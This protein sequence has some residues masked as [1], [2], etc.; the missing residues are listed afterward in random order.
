MSDNIIKSYSELIIRIKNNILSSRYHAATL[1]NKELLILY[2][3]IGK[4]ISDKTKTEKWGSKVLN[5]I[6]DDLQ[7]ELPGLRGFS[8][9]NMKKMRVF[10]EGWSKL[11]SISSISLNQ[12]ELISK[13]ESQIG[14]M[15]LNQFIE[16]FF[17]IGFSSHYLIVSKAKTLEERLFY[18]INILNN[19]W[20]VD[21]LKYHLKTSLY[22]QK[23]TLPT[24]FGKTI[25]KKD[26]RAKALGTFKDE[27]LLEYINIEDPDE[28]DEKLIENEIVRNIKKF[29]MSL[30]DDFSFIG[31]QYRVI[32]GGE[33]F[34]IDLLFY[35][36][37]LQSLVAIE[38]KKGKFKAEY[39]GKMNLYLSALDEYVK[40]PYENPSIGI[41]LCKEKNNKIVEFSFRDFD[42]S[43]GVATYKT[44]KDLPAKFKNILPKA[45]ELKK[46]MIQTNK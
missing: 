4:I 38:L 12:L 25:K 33:D 1:V 39:L 40:K 18:M 35:N 42:K 6:S 41:I 36:R 28:E 30:G 21:T 8:A 44:S 15:P 14:S 45:S 32:V 24:N 5:K 9:S 10:Y 34:Y 26:L 43:M 46:L 20:S 11:F 16:C 13:N 2:F 27:Y 3:N 29:I 37:T 7:K 22:S 17:R 19:F 23:A 31:N